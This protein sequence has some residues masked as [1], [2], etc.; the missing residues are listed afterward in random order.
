V[1]AFLNVFTQSW[2]LYRHSRVPKE[3]YNEMALQYIVLLP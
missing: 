2:F 3:R 1:P